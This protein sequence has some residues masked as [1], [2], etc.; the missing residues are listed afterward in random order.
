MNLTKG[1][2]VEVKE[3]DANGWWL[4]VKNGSEGWAP[5]N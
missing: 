2:S 1:E 5:S 4:V 3:K